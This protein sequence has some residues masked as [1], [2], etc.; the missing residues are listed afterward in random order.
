MASWRGAFGPVQAGDRT[1]GQKA[2]EFR[3]F[4]EFPK[5]VSAP[6]ELALE[7]GPGD[8]RD[9][10]AL[11]RYD[12]R[13]VNPQ[14][15]AGD[16][17]AFRNYV[18]QSGAEFSVAQGIYV[19]TCSGWFSDRS[20]R[21]L[22]SG[23]PVLIQDTGL[24]GMLPV[25]RGLVVFRTMEDAVAGAETILDNYAEHCRAARKVAEEQFD[26]DIVLSRFAAETGIAP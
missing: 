24:G 7:I 2:H 21:Y 17:E 13:L 15:V 3:R 20:V 18:Q 8:D 1:F 26:S 5:H 10:A 19:D 23:K 16:P 4:I 22:A 9:R 11:A 25:G 14:T 6:C 12:W